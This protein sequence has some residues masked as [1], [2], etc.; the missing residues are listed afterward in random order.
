[1]KASKTKVNFKDHRGEIRDIITHTPVDAVTWITC[2]KGAIRGNHYHKKTVQYDYIV[3]GS[4]LCISKAM[5]S[6]KK[7]KKILKAGDVA[8]HPAMEAHAFQALE[9]NTVFISLTKGPRNGG[10]Y[11]KDTIRLTDPLI[12]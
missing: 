5:P 4:M 3:S 2:T 8:Y 10:D 9:D 6:G 7:T 1:M 11:E 12:K